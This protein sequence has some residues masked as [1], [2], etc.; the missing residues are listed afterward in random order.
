MK[1]W[2]SLCGTRDLYNV[3]VGWNVCSHGAMSHIAQSLRQYILD[4]GMQ[5]SNYLIR[6]FFEFNSNRHFD[7]LS[8]T[9]K[10]LDLFPKRTP[11]SI[12]II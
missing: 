4:L 6:H 5:E 11:L 3:A 10:M 1:S 9:W 7:G 12:A 8:L 2:P